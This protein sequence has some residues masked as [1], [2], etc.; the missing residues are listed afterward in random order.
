SSSMTNPA[1][2]QYPELTSAVWDTTALLIPSA[3]AS[4]P[5]FMNSLEYFLVVWPKLMAQHRRR[6][7]P[8]LVFNRG[9]IFTKMH[10]IFNLINFKNCHLL[11][12][13]SGG[14]K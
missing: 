1:G 12:Y 7:K 10:F 9:K 8:S 14:G 11:Y 13:C 4:T 6:M 3:A 2:F 5:M